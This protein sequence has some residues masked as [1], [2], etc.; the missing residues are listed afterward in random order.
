M[1]EVILNKKCF[2]RE[3]VGKKVYSSATGEL[4]CQDS[5]NLDKHAEK[6]GYKSYDFKN[7]IFREYEDFACAYRGYKDRFRFF[8][9]MPVLTRG[10]GR[11]KYVGGK[12]VK[13]YQCDFFPDGHIQE[14]GVHNLEYWKKYPELPLL[15]RE[16]LYWIMYHNFHIPGIDSFRMFV[17]IFLEKGFAYQ[18]LI[19]KKEAQKVLEEMESHK[20]EPYFPSFTKSILNLERN[21]GAIYGKLI[22]GNEGQ[23]MLALEVVDN[24]TGIVQKALVGP[25]Y[26]YSHDEWYLEK[27]FC[28]SLSCRVSKDDLSMFSE[29]YPFYKLSNYIKAGGENIL[30]PLLSPK[31]NRVLDMLAKGKCIHM[32]ER[33]YGAVYNSSTLD[34]DGKNLVEV[35]GLPH[36][37]L[38]KISPLCFIED[39][40]IRKLQK[41]QEKAPYLL[42][43]VEEISWTHLDFF[44]ANILYRFTNDHLRIRGFRQLSHEMQVEVTKFLFEI[45]EP[46]DFRTYIDYLN[47]CYYLDPN[48][49]MFGYTP[50]DVVL[51]H[52]RVRAIYNDERRFTEFEERNF[53]KAISKKEYYSRASDYGKEASKLADDPYQIR[54][55]GS[56]SEMREEGKNLHHC[57]AT[58]VKYVMEETTQ[59]FFLRKKENP[60]KSFATIEVREDSVI[61]V[62]GSCNKKIEK[63][64]QLYVIKW[65][66][67]KGLKIDTYDI[68]VGVN[69]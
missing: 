24:T 6:N 18:E 66:E 12:W 5:Y 3:Q 68:N 51:A 32:A 41:V 8:V 25:D 38:K 43:G 67:L 26:F 50:E 29:A 69:L 57:V 45:C 64:A 63:D 39:K 4:L 9:Y 37:V 40:M 54:L 62:K 36:R 61:Q 17:D 58:Y 15:N 16:S 52:D 47:M 27:Q 21:E 42:R 44:D 48:Q 35:F 33:F 30:I 28:L 11:K 13:I 1:N 59:I 53:K 14:E 34:L 22:H 10:Y 65:A 60:E 2:I 20:P 46:R 23:L 56:A 31:Y 49:P 55:P 19:S 7:R